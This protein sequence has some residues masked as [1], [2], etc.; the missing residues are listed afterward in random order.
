TG[1]RSCPTCGALNGAEFSRC[2]RC[3]VS[4]SALAGHSSALGKV[5]GKVIDG[6]AL[7][8]SKIFAGLTLLIF[9]AEARTEMAN[10]LDFPLWEESGRVLYRFGGLIPVFELVRAEPWRLLSAVF[11]HVGALH[12]ALNLLTLA[13]LSR[14]L[15][16]EIGSARFAIAYVTSGIMG[17]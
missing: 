5:L 1:A 3:G 4:L 13:S 10:G 9:A 16:P 17:F 6:R 11:V 7:L 15:E 8:A 12:I 14:A 2:V